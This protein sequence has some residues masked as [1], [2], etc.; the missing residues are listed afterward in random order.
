M[1]NTANR[2]ADE[3]F[4]GPGLGFP[5]EWEWLEAEAL[6]GRNLERR[7]GQNHPHNRAW[8]RA[9]VKRHLRMWTA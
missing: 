5:E 3:R 2:I 7:N 4:P 9:Q 1:T 6:V 8:M